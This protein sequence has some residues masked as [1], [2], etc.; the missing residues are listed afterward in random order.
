MLKNLV[1]LLLHIL[2]HHLVH[3]F[4]FIFTLFIVSSQVL[5][6]TIKTLS[7]EEGVN[8]TSH[9]QQDPIHGYA[10]LDLTSIILYD[11]LNITFSIDDYQG[12][13]SVL[14]SHHVLYFLLFIFI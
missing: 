8:C 1:I 12:E 2:F 7:F 3:V 6:N 13:G 11:N 4:L 14:F 10:I 9:I 5:P